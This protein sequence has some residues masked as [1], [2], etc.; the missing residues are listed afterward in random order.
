M[1]RVEWA[2]DA[3]LGK[4]IAAAERG[5]EA[6]A[7]RA[8]EFSAS[9]MPGSG[10]GV[11]GK[12]AKGRNVYRP[13]RPGQPPGVRTNRL[14]G[15]ITSG[16]IGDLR[17]AFGMNVKYGRFLEQGTRFMQP[18]PFLAPVVSKRKRELVSVFNRT[19]KAEVG[20]QVIRGAMA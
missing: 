4:V 9:S 15:A 5:L 20:R 1:S 17:H 14:K 18:R 8:S 16:R 2:G 12:T 7:F 6:A 13:S 19:V 3:F 10:A 11:K